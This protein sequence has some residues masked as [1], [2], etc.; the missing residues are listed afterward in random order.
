M[1]KKGHFA[2]M[3]LLLA[4]LPLVPLFGQ[5]SLKL[6]IVPSPN[7][8]KN[9]EFIHVDG[10]GLPGEWTFDNCSKS[11]YFR[12]QVVRH[13]DGSFLAVDSEWIKFGYWLQT[14]PVKEGGSYYAS[15]EVQSDGPTPAIWIQCNATKKST[16]KSPGKLRYL[17]ARALRYG[18][19]LR[20]TLRDFV[21]EDLIINLSPVRWNR[22]DSEVIIPTDRGIERCTLRVGIYGGDAGQARFRNPVFREAKAELKAEI[23]GTGW[24]ELRVSGAKPERVKLDSASGK[25]DI[26]L[27]LP[28]APRVYRAELLGPTGRKVVK[29]ISNE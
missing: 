6:R 3:A 20:E 1:R 8:I 28:Q 12:S 26:L 27:V 24:T 9:A 22:L 17:I 16:K 23:F 2:C 4:V 21:D 5:E 18:D 11:Q 13:S 7:L 10:D 19:E 14:I 15:C 29:E 25:Q